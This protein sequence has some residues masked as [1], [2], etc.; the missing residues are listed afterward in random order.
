MRI[1]IKEES[2]EVIKQ[3][4]PGSGAEDFVVSA[5]VQAIKP[6]GVITIANTNAKSST[7]GQ[8]SVGTG[9]ALPAPSAPSTPPPAPK[10]K[11]ASK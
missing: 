3:W 8:G 7:D 5:N 4:L 6:M 11:K 1:D 9:G 10:E 2:R